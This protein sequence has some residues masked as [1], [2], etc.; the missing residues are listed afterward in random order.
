MNTKV[1]PLRLRE[2]PTAMP[3][4]AEGPYFHDLSVGGIEVTGHPNGK[5][6]AL[7][8]SGGEPVMISSDDSGLSSHSF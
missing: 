5:R 4:S 6:K 3:S 7:E 8:T 2:V 1:A